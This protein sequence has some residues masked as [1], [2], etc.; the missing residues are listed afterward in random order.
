GR[1]DHDALPSGDLAYVKLV[2]H[3]AGLGRRSTVD[4]VESY[5]APYAPYRALAGLFALVD[6]RRAMAT[7]RPLR[8]H[9]PRP[10][11]DQVA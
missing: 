8:Y 9:P 10:E 4:E 6:S 3:L 5:F 11:I 2:G 1:G 7:A